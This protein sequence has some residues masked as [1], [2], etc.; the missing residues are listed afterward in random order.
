MYRWLVRNNRLEAAGK[1]L[2]KLDNKSAED[3]RKTIAQIQHTLELEEAIESGS[4]YLDLFKGTDRRRTEVVCLTFAGQVLS[5][6]TF[7]YGPTYFFQQAGISTD[8]S[9]QIA[10]GGTGIAFVGTVSRNT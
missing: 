4:S 3:H 10:V 8:N 6:S 1:S 5:G 9:Y 7:A 2:C